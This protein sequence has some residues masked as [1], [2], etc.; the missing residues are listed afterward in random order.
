MAI[1]VQANLLQLK[2]A[3]IRRSGPSESLQ[4]INVIS[5]GKVRT[6][7][8]TLIDRRA[9]RGYSDFELEVRLRELWG[10]FCVMSWLFER[11]PTCGPVDF[12]GLP[13][14]APTR[15]DTEIEFKHAEVHAFLWRLRF[16]QR[17]RH[18]VEYAA[19]PAFKRDQLLAARVPATA[20]G[21]LTAECSDDELL[22]GG[23]EYAGMLAVLRWA[24][25]RG[26]D[27]G[28]AGIMDVGDT[29]F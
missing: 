6:F 1:A 10:Q 22:L 23:C 24:M 27:W 4:T 25:D 8:E 28:A 11:V 19:S 2:I 12:A 14:D 18:D 16:E 13:M 17:R 29:P 21:K 26:R 7:R 15:C 20:F 5:P 9:I 3:A